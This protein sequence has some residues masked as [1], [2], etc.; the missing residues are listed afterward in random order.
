[1]QRW[2]LGKQGEALNYGDESFSDHAVVT[3]AP[4]VLDRCTISFFLKAR[5]EPETSNSRIIGPQSQHWVLISNGVFDSGDHVAFQ[6]G[7]Y[8]MGP[9]LQSVPVPESSSL[10]VLTIGLLG[11]GQR[12][13]RTRCEAM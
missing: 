6:D 3:S 13:R 9:R 8:E 10:V 4:I 1:M 12:R 5:F 7:G 2:V 11:M